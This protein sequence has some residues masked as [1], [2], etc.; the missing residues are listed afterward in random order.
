M[1][2]LEEQTTY[3]FRVAASNAIGYGQFGSVT[4]T[5][6]SCRNIPSLLHL[7]YNN[8]DNQNCEDYVT[9]QDSNGN[10]YWVSIVINGVMMYPF[11][12]ALF[13]YW[14]CLDERYGQFETQALLDGVA[15][16]ISSLLVLIELLL[17]KF[18]TSGSPWVFIIINPFHLI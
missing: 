15:R 18:P 14:L 16:L 11:F 12:Y 9:A 2:G 10:L 1:H 8:N 17:P 3:Y 4:I 13:C 5:T 7:H 6:I